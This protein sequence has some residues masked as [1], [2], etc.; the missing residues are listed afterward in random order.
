MATNFATTVPM[1]CIGPLADW[2]GIKPVFA[3]LGA[4]MFLIAALPWLFNVLHEAR[5]TAC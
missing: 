2:I 1:A 4:G 5:R 3:L